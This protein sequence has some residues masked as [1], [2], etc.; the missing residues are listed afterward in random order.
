MSNDKKLQIV[1]AGDGML[2]S[3]NPFMDLYV[4]AQTGKKKP[5]IAMLP[6]A[7][8]DSQNLIK[9]FYSIFERY[10]CEPS[11]LSL[12]NP[13]TA[14]IRDYIMS[15]DVIF[16]SGGQSKSMLGV[17][18][19]WLLPDMLKAAYENGTVLSGGSAG[20]VCWFDE[21]ITDSIPGSL[22][23]MK[24]LGFLPYSN[25]PHFANFSRRSAYARHL[26][27][28]NIKQGYAA[29]DFAA[30]HFVNGKH[31]RSVST[32]HYAQ[33]FH[34]SVENGNVKRDKLK[35]EWLGTKAN[36]EKFIFNSAM[37]DEP[38]LDNQDND[39]YPSEIVSINGRGI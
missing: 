17:W 36:Q 34:L 35:T 39:D 14:D 11:H 30:L 26:L 5:K 9:Y 23:A 38:L 1:A 21:C 28:G 29:D 2:D 18:K 3:E 31:F 15:Q 4:L 25:S 16:V 10:P 6:T 27:A 33:T 20:S 13:H 8:G 12:F 22:T 37:F 24:C 19:E 7:S 32:R